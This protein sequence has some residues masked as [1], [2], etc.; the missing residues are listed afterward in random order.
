[1]LPKAQ[2]PPFDLLRAVQV[3]FGDQG[4]ILLRRELLAWMPRLLLNVAGHGGREPDLDMHGFFAVED[5][6][7]LGHVL[8]EI[9]IFGRLEVELGD[10]GYWP[11]GKAF[12]IFFGQTPMSSPGKI[13]PASAVN[14]IGKVVGDV[15]RFKDVLKESEITLERV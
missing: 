13:I 3:E 14:I 8:V 12:C 5:A 15:D 4:S 1:M 9:K 7:R 10:L 11:T 6:E 2:H